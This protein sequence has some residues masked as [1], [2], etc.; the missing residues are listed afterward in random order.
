M[1]DVRPDPKLVTEGG[2]GRKKPPK[3]TRTRGRT[4]ATREQWDTIR[5]AK[6]YTGYCRLCGRAR[7]SC[8]AHHLIPRASGGDDVPDNIVG[9]CPTCHGEVTRNSP[10]HRAALG[11]LLTDAEYA[12][13]VGKL[14]E[15]G[16]SRLFGV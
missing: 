14:G 15:G 13:I 7:L 5:E 6:L 3:A 12:Y 2:I 1:V 9:L 4:F 11:A 10:A 8:E 16:M